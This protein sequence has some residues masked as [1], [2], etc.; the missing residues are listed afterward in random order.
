MKHEPNR[1]MSHGSRRED[2][3]LVDVVFWY[4]VDF[5]LLQQMP[6]VGFVMLVIIGLSGPDER[7][8]IFRR[9]LRT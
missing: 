3:Q 1:P 8:G 6:E 9:L 2:K 7:R 4:F 5:F